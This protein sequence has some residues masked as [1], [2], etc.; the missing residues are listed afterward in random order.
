VC[1]KKKKTA[2][3][4]QNSVSARSHEQMSQTCPHFIRYAW[5][6]HV[7]GYKNSSIYALTSFWEPRKCPYRTK[8]VGNGAGSKWG[9]S[10]GWWRHS[11]LF[12]DWF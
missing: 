12:L 6:L 11:N 1:A 8:S 10:G 5:L 9:D 4:R 2:K 7:A 3:V